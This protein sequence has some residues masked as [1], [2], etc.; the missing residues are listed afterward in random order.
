MK[1][2]FWNDNSPLYSVE[3]KQKNAFHALDIAL[4]DVVENNAKHRKPS[5]KLHINKM[6]CCGVERRIF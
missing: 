1:V 6:T 5:D 3:I 2:I 4:F